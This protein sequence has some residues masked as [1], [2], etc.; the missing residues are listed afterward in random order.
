MG[1]QTIYLSGYLFVRLLVWQ[2]FNIST[3][4]P[5]HPSNIKKRSS[6]VNKI[7]HS[8]NKISQVEDQTIVDRTEFSTYLSIGL[9]SGNAPNLLRPV[10]GFVP[11]SGEVFGHLAETNPKRK[12]YE[13]SNRPEEL[14]CYFALHT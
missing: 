6:Q 14:C 3:L 9:A 12:F 8:H 5:T 2:I 4:P 7:M 1:E 13:Q 10:I 11:G